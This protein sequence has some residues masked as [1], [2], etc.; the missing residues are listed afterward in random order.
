MNMEIGTTRN[1]SGF[2][3]TEDAMQLIQE[4]VDLD[5]SHRLDKIPLFESLYEMW[6]KDLVRGNQ[7]K[8]KFERN[9][10][11]IKETIEST[12]SEKEKED[13]RKVDEIYDILKIG[14][15]HKNSS[16]EIIPYNAAN[17]NKYQTLHYNFKR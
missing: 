3:L 9:E 15:P 2:V 8:D 11:F 12:L 10:K 7:A 6:E 1:I 16:G 5:N 17:V 13:M 14:L 4:L